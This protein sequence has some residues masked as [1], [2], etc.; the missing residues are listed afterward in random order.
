MT[1][2]SNLDDPPRPRS[3]QRP[4][5]PD[6]DPSLHPNPMPSR[7]L[8]E[9]LGYVA[10]D[11][12]QIYT[13]LGARP[14]RINAV[15]VRWTGGA[16]GR[17]K[18]EVVSSKP[19]EPTPRVNLAP[20]R[21][22][23]TSGGLQEKGYIRADQISPNFT[24]DD[25]IYSMYEIQ[26]LPDGYQ[27]VWD[28]FIDDRDGRTVK[29]RLV[30]KGPPERH[31]TRLEWSCEFLRQDENESREVFPSPITHSPEELQAGSEPKPRKLY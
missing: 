10:D 9:S 21:N 13:N 18:Q 12:R 27:A 25:I 31:P 6:R 20:L 17:G 7:S 8:V 26:P 24:E 15:V 19:V 28:M 4:V 23:M 11:L 1:V 14:Y 30:P 16:I 3:N 22:E 29:R 2:K 5:P